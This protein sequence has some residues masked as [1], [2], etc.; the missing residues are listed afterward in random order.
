MGYPIL[1]FAYVLFWG[2]IQGFPERALL[3]VPLKGSIW[4]LRR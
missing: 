4:I 2:P 3:R 1:I